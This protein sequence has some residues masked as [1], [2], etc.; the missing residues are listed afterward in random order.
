[1]KKNLYLIILTVF[2][3][4][5]LTGCYNTPLYTQAKRTLE[6]LPVNS[7]N[8]YEGYVQRNDVQIYLQKMDRR[9]MQKYFKKN[10]SSMKNDIYFVVM[11]NV[12]ST[13]IITMTSQ[14]TGINGPNDKIEFK[15]DITT[16]ARE[17]IKYINQATLAGTVFSCGLVLIFE[18]NA[19]NGDHNTNE[20]YAESYYQ[21]FFERALK[22]RVLYPNETIQGFLI[23]P[24]GLRKIDGKL[25]KC[26]FK[27]LVFTF[28]NATKI[29]Y[30]NVEYAL[31]K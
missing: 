7:P 30:F 1:M 28:Q 20:K 21:S 13:P 12:G 19:F 26:N 5:F 14:I 3:S 17:G 15:N 2:C 25:R 31:I 23:V 6:Q 24:K 27:S 16:V 8:T 11:K 29:E 18:P 4:V 10:P 22:N 9:E